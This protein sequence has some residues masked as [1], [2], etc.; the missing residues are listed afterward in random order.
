MLGEELFHAMP[1]GGL[2]HLHHGGDLGVTPS[3]NQPSPEDYAVSLG[4]NIIID[5]PGEA[6]V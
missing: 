4:M 5:I 1:A 2:V 6:G 3:V